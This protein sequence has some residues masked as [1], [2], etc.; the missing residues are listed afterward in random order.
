MAS[1]DELLEEARAELTR[2]TPGDAREAMESGAIFIDIR[3]IEQR[4][5]DGEI[6]GA[7]VI[8]RNVLEWR[9]DPTSDARDPKVDCADRQVIV[10]C[11]AGYASSF[12]AATLRRLGLDATDMVGGFQRWREEGLPIRAGEADSEGKQSRD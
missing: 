6:P 10:L 12:A 3:P 4:S 2:V 8:A 9:L 5:R 1:V 11:D 7:H